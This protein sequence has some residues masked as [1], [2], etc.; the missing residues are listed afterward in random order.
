MEHYL[1]Y[2]ADNKVDRRICFLFLELVRDLDRFRQ[3]LKNLAND[4]PDINDAFLTM[5][6]ALDPLQVC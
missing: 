6:K 2:V 1:K 4:D 5:K 3:E